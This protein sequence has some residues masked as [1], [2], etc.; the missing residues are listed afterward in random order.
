[1]SSICVNCHR[2]VGCSCSLLEKKF[3]SEKCKIE[4]INKENESDNLLH[5]LQHH[6]GSDSQ[7]RREPLQKNKE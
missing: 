2:V 4:F 1:M 7:N 5:Q 3:C 6:Q